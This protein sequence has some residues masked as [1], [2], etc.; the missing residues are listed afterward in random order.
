MNLD[1]AIAVVTVLLLV[2][3]WISRSILYPPFIFCFMW[4]F[5][6]VLCRLQ[7]IDLDPIH[8]I[9]LWVV[10]AGALAFTFGGLFAYL[11]PGSVLRTRLIL[12]PKLQRT[13]L[14]KLML[15]GVT[16][17]AFPHL[18]HHIAEEASKGSG[19]TI[20][21]R[22][23]QAS[24]DESAHVETDI[25]VI[26]FLPI[27]TFMAVLFLIEK[28]DR[29]FWA[30]LSLAGVVNLLSG[31]RTGFLMLIAALSCVQLV[32]TGRLSFMPAARVLKIPVAIFIVLYVVLIFVNKNTSD[33]D[34][35]LG[36]I[37]FFFIVSYVVG[38]LAALDH[39]L[40]HPSEYL[41]AP[42]H[43]FE[44]LLKIADFLHLT[45]YTPPPLLDQFLA[46]PFPTNVYT[47]Y[48]FYF[49]DFG[50]Y[51]CFFCVLL[52]GFLQSALYRKARA[53]SELGLFL[54]ALSMY[55][56]VMV[57]FDD[58]YFVNLGFFIRAA[59]FCIVYLNLRGLPLVFLPGRR[60]HLTSGL[61]RK[62][63]ALPDGRGDIP[64]S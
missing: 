49:T 13:N 55:P 48:K 32:K 50:L 35:G 14:P 47:V 19:D 33:V 36:K 53:G 41:A 29:Y 43:T 52:I 21:Q 26:S 7:L 42:N 16:L 58:L 61:R 40:Q 38:P 20:L 59:I 25:I 6:L 27:T 45:K 10:S 15:I 51:G 11:I 34:G 8:Q 64:A 31:G 9:T 28:R 46:V 12:S 30:A 60:I 1:W 57:I 3:Y 22:A 17:L 39:V 18:L 54:L 4:V 62:N 23:R 24:G 63:R 56:L 37:A 5:D 2:N 44:F